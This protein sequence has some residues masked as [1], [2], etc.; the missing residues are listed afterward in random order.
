MV[1]RH[2]Y[3]VSVYA[4]RDARGEVFMVNH[5]IPT[6]TKSKSKTHKFLGF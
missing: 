2:G 5:Q 6:Y 4:K 1:A 3:V